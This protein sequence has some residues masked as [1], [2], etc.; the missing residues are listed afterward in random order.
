M[1][2][3]QEKEIRFGNE[4]NNLIVFMYGRQ[5]TSLVSV[6]LNALVLSNY[7]QTGCCS[8]LN[9]HP[10]LT[11]G[12][13]SDG[14]VA[15]RVHVGLHTLGNHKLF[16]C[17]HGKEAKVT[18][19]THSHGSNK[20]TKSCLKSDGFGIYLARWVKYRL[21]ITSMDQTYANPILPG[22]RCQLS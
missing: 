15:A 2:Q 20:I 8:Q 11:S 16:L 21:L 9:A 22:A 13:V 10:L 7:F 12:T 4:L 1:E 18:M 19:N 14:A 17:S 5:Y 3:I 6:K